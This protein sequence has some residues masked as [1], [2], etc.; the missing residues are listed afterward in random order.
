MAHLVF[1]ADGDLPVELAP[2][3][4]LGRV[5]HRHDGT[6]DGFGQ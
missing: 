5:G 1:L 4:L 3:E 6:G 2:G